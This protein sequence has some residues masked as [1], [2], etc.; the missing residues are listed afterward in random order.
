[1]TAGMPLPFLAIDHPLMAMIARVLTAALFAGFVAGIIV[2]MAQAWQTQPLIGSAEL[3]EAVDAAHAV[4]DDHEAEAWSPTDGLERWIWTISSN[5]LIGVGFAC[6]LAAAMTLSGR[7]ATAREGVLWGLAG[8]AVFSV[9]PALGAPPV[10]PG[11]ETAPLQDRKIWWIGT[12]MVSAAGLWLVAL[13]QV[14]W[15]N[16][17][18]VLLLA[19][20]HLVGA[21]A[22]VLGQKETLPPQ[23]AA[24][25]A[26]ATLFVSGLFWTALGAT[27][28]RLLR[29]RDTV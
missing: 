13:V 28:G 8:F 7:P 12:T 5:V 17:L 29:S 23:L 21:P 26:V 14:R 6:V 10:L 18:G 25:F 2:S 19:L 9:A 20:P 1:M 11:M 16:V 3:L 22:L 4:A 15:I 24:Q 27:L